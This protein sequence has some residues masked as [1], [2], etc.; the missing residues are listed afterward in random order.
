MAT[1][2]QTPELDRLSAAELRGLVIGLLGTVAKL[3][4]QVA[5]LTEE[6]ARLKTLKGR[7]Q[8]KPSGMEKQ[9]SFFQSLMNRWCS[10]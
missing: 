8:L 5:A 6:N 4:G 7:P 1:R 10:L 2:L 9:P 3:E